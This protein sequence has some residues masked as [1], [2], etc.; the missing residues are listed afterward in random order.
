MAEMFANLET[1]LTSADQVMFNAILKGME[2]SMLW[3]HALIL[4]RTM[5]LGHSLK[6]NLITYNTLMSTCQ[7]CSQWERSLHFF[8]QLGL[9][10]LI[11]DLVSYNTCLAAC[12]KGAA[13]QQALQ[14]W[15]PSQHRRRVI[16]KSPFATTVQ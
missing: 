11:P 2:K 3:Q 16:F 1:S 8:L 15:K 5:E 9:V 13:W 7:K 12:R 14:L 10:K 6:G 4:L